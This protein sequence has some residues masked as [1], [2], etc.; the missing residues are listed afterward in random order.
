MSDRV[1]V[2][3]D[4]STSSRDALVWAAREARLREAPLVVVHSRFRPSYDPVFAGG[5]YP[6]VAEA[7]QDEVDG[8][9]DLAAEVVAQVEPGLKVSGVTR[10]GPAALVLLDVANEGAGLVVV[11]SRGLGAFGA[12][13]LGS[14]S[15]HLAA[16]SPAPVVVVPSGVGF[17]T[18]GPVL[19][20]VDGSAGGE[21]ATV[22]AAREAVLRDVPLDVVA[23]YLV[24][25]DPLV[26]SLS[27]S[28]DDFR[29]SFRARAHEVAEA[30][31][32]RAKQEGPSLTVRTHVVEGPP[33]QEIVK[34]AEAGSASLVVVGSRGHGE[35]VGPVLGS[36]SQ[37]VLRHATTPV[38]VAHQ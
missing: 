16:R 11:G 30:A 1:V 26:T 21:A 20:A 8:V 27:P 38:L 18:A 9:L 29:G 5:F 3:I 34:A 14:V 6:P 36:V 23:A 32:T 25:A 12:F 13:F 15:I 37:G 28:V 7:S 31:A 22:E 24:P 33:A 4:G 19:V 35:V 17:S 10:S 2:G